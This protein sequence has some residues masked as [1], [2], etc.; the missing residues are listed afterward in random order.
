MPLEAVIPVFDLIGMVGFLVAV[1]IGIRNYRTTEFEKIFWFAFIFAAALGA[2][3]LGLVTL[4]WLGIRSVL[5]DLFSTSLQAV[6]IGVFAIGTIGT[7]AIVEDLKASRSEIVR[8]HQKTKAARSKAEARKRELEQT[9]SLLHEV[10]QMADIGGWELNCNTDEIRWTDGTREI[11]GVLDAPP[12]NLSAALDFFHVDDRGTL[13]EAIED[14]RQSGISYDL[15]CRIITSDGQERWVQTR[16]ARIHNEDVPKLRGVIQNI[17]ARKEREQR[18]MVLNRILRHNLRNKVTIISGYAEQL[19]NDLTRLDFPAAQSTTDVRETIETLA[20]STDDLEGNLSILQQLLEEIDQFPT[21]EAQINVKN[22]LESSTDLSSLSARARQF[23][24]VISTEN[25][26]ESIEIKS[27]LTNLKAEYQETYPDAEIELNSVDITI[28]GHT[29][30]IR[31]ALGEL[32]ENAIKH[33]EK[34]PSH[35]NIEVTKANADRVSI[36]VLDN[37]PGIPTMER[38]VLANGEETPL[39]HGS[40]LGLWTVH[41]IATRFGASIEITDN[42]PAGS[43]VTLLFP[44][45]DMPES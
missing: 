45:G 5:L 25:V 23:Q 18:L 9:Q 12:L 6:V 31:V 36:Q 17:T 24:Q 38:E 3:W 29:D 43:I 22:I 20:R 34:T 8:Q 39:L 1:I 15:E 13:R 40:G 37:G 41:W 14:C 35:V 33:N 28:R 7:R 30:G 21:E 26:Q 19:E 4:E 32:I 11:F 2:V 42:Q 10:E 27:L 16:G 44:M